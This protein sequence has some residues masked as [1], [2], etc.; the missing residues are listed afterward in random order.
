VRRRC[1]QVACRWSRRFGRE[2]LPHLAVSPVGEAIRHSAITETSAVAPFLLLTGGSWNNPMTIQ[3]P[4]ATQYD[5]R[6]EELKKNSE[7]RAAFAQLK[8]KWSEFWIQRERKP[9]KCEAALVFLETHFE[10]NRVDLLSSRYSQTR[11]KA[12]SR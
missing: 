7:K 12:Q 11:A 8:V 4:P 6:F 3:R 5:T 2:V 9:T 10:H 1:K